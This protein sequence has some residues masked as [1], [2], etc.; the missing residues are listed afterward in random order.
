MS[1]TLIIMRRRP[2]SPPRTTRHAGIPLRPLTRKSSTVPKRPESVSTTNPCVRRNLFGMSA[3][4]STRPPLQFG[5]PRWRSAGTGSPEDERAGDLAPQLRM[6]VVTTPEEAS[7]VER[8]HRREAAL[9]VDHVTEEERHADVAGEERVATA[10]HRGPL[11]LDLAD[12]VHCEG[13]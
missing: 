1:S 11:P 6:I 13:A 10:A 3:L 4:A 8:S 12:R 5:T 2:N 7:G 9:A